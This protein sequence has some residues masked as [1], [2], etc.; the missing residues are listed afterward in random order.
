MTGTN[1]LEVL[2]L[3]IQLKFGD[4]FERPSAFLWSGVANNIAY[5]AAFPSL[6]SVSLNIKFVLDTYDPDDESEQRA[7]IEA[8]K[9]EDFGTF[10]EELES[11]LR[12]LGS[13]HDIK[14]EWSTV[15]CTSFDLESAIV[16]RLGNG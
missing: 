11:V 4:N 9:E 13:R 7:K 3:G 14:L 6:K 10:D 5:K 12:P 16:Q 15:A 1:V 8:F 2:S